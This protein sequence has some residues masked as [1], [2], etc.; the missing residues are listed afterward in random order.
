MTVSKSDDLLQCDRRNESA[1]ETA[2]LT[3]LRAIRG[4]VRAPDR[5]LWRNDTSGAT[6]AS[7][8]MVREYERATALAKHKEYVLARVVSRDPCSFCGVRKDIGCAHSKVAA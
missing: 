1:M 4:K 5:L 8:G 7:G 3:L 2:S 6:W